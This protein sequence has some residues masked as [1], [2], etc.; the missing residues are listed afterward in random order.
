MEKWQTTREGISGRYYEG[1][2]MARPG[3]PMRGA[4]KVRGI[5]GNLERSAGQ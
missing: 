3:F 1:D 2:L 4:G 5:W